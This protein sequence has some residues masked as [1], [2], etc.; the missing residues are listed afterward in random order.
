MNN[1]SSVCFFLIFLASG[2]VHAGSPDDEPRRLA[3]G[4]KAGLSLATYGGEDADHE[5]VESTNT[6]GLVIGGFASISF[7]HLAAVQPEFIFATKGS[8]VE[9][10]GVY[11]GGFNLSYL[12]IPVMARVGIPLRGLIKPYI[13]A[14]PQLS[15]LLSSEIEEADG[16]TSD[17]KDDTHGVD[18]GLILGAGAAINVSSLGG[19]MLIEARYDWGLRKVY[20]DGPFDLQ[21]R[22]ISFLIGYQY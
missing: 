6:Y 21:T 14:G 17:A 10:G 19:A 8:D 20:P 3:I 4:G 2:S 16:Q 7:H 18:V 5:L 9:A 11:S 22:T 12:E 13:L 15:I 1:K